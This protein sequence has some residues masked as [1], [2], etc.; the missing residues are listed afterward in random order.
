MR[1]FMTPPR[2]PGKAPL[3]PGV[4]VG[5]RVLWAR[6]VDGVWTTNWV[7]I[8]GPTIDGG[9]TF[10]RVALEDGTKALAKPR[11]LATRNG[12]DDA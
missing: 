2:H 7:T 1:D 5:D 9:T 6:Y 8:L 11:H 3:L 12:E 10:L 4:R